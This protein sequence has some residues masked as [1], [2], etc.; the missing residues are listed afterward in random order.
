MSRELLVTHFHAPTHLP[1]L[2]SV[3]NYGNTRSPALVDSAVRYLA[4]CKQRR[5]RWQRR[6][7]GQHI[8]WHTCRR[9]G[10]EADERR[11]DNAPAAL[12]FVQFLTTTKTAAAPRSTRNNNNNKVRQTLACLVSPLHVTKAGSAFAS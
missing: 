9:A 12:A 3:T 6:R 8:P 2:C 10:P 11:Q 1:R 5:R 7:R 4:L